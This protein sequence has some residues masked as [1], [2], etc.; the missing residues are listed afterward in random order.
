MTFVWDALDPDVVRVDGV[1]Y[2]IWEI[3]P[4]VLGRR[5]ERRQRQER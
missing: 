5:D 4:K 1:A 2:L 3:D